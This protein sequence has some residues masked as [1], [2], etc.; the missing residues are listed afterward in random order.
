MHKRIEPRYAGGSCLT[1]R[2]LAQRAGVADLIRNLVRRPSRQHRKIARSLIEKPP[3]LA[4]SSSHGLT[5]E[6]SRRRQA[7]RACRRAGLVDQLAKR[8]QRGIGEAALKRCED[9]KQSRHD[10]GRAPPRGGLGDRILE[11]LTLQGFQLF[12][13]AGAQ[14]CEVFDLG[15]RWNRLRFQIQPCEKC[16]HLSAGGVT[17]G[18]GRLKAFLNG[19]LLGRKICPEGATQLPMMLQSGDLDG[20]VC[21]TIL[22]I[23]VEA[24]V[25]AVEHRDLLQCGRRRCC[26]NPIEFGDRVVANLET[27]LY[28]K[29]PI[30]FGFEDVALQLVD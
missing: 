6:L 23:D 29:R 11:K 28:L 18:Q 15:L 5:G 3:G 17:G 13:L 2:L 12:D 26:R 19:A 10:L 25:L 22:L 1:Q 16:L 4:A 27:Q 21:N 8:R 24:S 20:E 9:F 14:A 30:G 7:G